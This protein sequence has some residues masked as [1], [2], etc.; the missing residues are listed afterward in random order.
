MSS[1]EAVPM[2]AHVPLGALMSVFGSH[3]SAVTSQE[4]GTALA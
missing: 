2:S 3:V 1:R 4:A